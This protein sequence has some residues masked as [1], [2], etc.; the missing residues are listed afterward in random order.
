MK[1]IF[2][3][4]LAIAFAQG[5]DDVSAVSRPKKPERYAMML[6]QLARDFHQFADPL[7]QAGDAVILAAGNQD[8]CTTSYTLN[9]AGDPQLVFSAMAARQYQC[10]VVVI[11]FRDIADG[12]AAGFKSSH[13]GPE[14]LHDGK[15]RLEAAGQAKPRFCTEKQGSCPLPRRRKHPGF[16]GIKQGF[17]GIA[18]RPRTRV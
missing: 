2:H 1:P 7:A 16:E 3:Q 18:H 5:E 13:I 14:T 10:E 17:Q 11:P 15:V 4:P 9:G 12:M 8:R 6:G